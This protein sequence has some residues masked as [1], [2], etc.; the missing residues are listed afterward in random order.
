MTERRLPGQRVSILP[1]SDP[2]EDQMDEPTQPQVKMPDAF[3]KELTPEEERTF[4][5]W[6]QD[7]YT[8]GDWISP[9]W[10][11]VVRDEC[12]KINA[13]DMANE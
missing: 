13:G 12:E 1:Q 9:L 5:K 3:F 6:A 10:H 2:Q 8:P 4:R 7:N 11:P